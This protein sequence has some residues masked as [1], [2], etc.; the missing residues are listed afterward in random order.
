ML[1]LETA[2]DIGKIASLMQELV[3][4]DKAQVLGISRETLARSGHALDE[5]EGM[6]QCASSL[7]KI[8]ATSLEDAIDTEGE[9]NVHT[10]P[11]VQA[12]MDEDLALV[13]TSNG[14]AALCTG[15]KVFPG[16]GPTQHMIVSALVQCVRTNAIVEI[17]NGFGQDVSVRGER[18]NR[19]VQLFLKQGLEAFLGSCYTH[20]VDDGDPHLTLMGQLCGNRR[21]R[22]L[23]R[24]AGAMG[25]VGSCYD[26]RGERHGKTGTNRNARRVYR[27]LTG[28]TYRFGSCLLPCIP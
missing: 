8:L 9:L 28:R 26:G 17:N 4:L 11:T 23:L 5:A 19:R 15:L 27:R 18:A 6:R 3:A 2:R 10:R 7:G 24:R 16:D 25:V 12:L 14:I 13:D 20:F 21:A 1:P 22:F